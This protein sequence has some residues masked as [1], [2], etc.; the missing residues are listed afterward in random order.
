MNPQP[1][2]RDARPV[3]I[4]ERHSEA[5]IVIGGILMA[6]TLLFLPLGIFCLFTPLFEVGIGFLV[7]SAI[8]GVP[9]VIL[10]THGARR[11]PEWLE[12]RA[13]A[14]QTVQTQS[15]NSHKDGTTMK[16]FFVLLLL[17]T[18]LVVSSLFIVAT[19]PTRT[20]PVNNGNNNGANCAWTDGT[21][22]HPNTNQCALP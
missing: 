3:V 14:V 20:G 2:T 4:R 1:R 15:T 7:L 5:E 13:A 10:W 12:A 19:I 9:G 18:L 21:P 16:L 6:P 17:S 22:S 11:P 8:C